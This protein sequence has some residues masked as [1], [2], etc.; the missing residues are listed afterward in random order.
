MESPS[1]T[2]VETN[3]VVE[4]YDEEVLLIFEIISFQ[5]RKKV[6]QYIFVKKIGQGAF[7]KVKLAYLKDDPSQK[8]VS[9]LTIHLTLSKAVKIFRKSHLRKKKEY[10][11]KKEGGMGFKSQL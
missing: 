7:G 8:F 6:N 5:G 11:R 3:E 10:F 4:C 1:R 2:V 9:H